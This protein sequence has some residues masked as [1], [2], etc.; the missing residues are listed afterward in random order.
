MTP[1][2]VLKLAK[3]R[4][5]EFL[6]LKFCDF[7]GMWQHFGLPVSQLTEDLFEEGVGFDGS[8]IRGWQP[9]HHSDMVIRPNP[10]SA[11]VEPFA[12][13]PTLSF[14]CNVF[15]PITGQ[16]YNISSGEFFL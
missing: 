3:E 7:P 13:R 8:S 16:A 11:R 10:A 2:D 12:A 1:K 5:I 15:D 4:N 9:I 14:I 6:D